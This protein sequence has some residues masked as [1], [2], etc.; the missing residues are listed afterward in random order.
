MSWNYDAWLQNSSAYEEWAGISEDYD[1]DE[2][3]NIKDEQYYRDLRADMDYEMEREG[4]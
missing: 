2:D 4:V 3:G 1:V